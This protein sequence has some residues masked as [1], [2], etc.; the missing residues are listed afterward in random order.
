MSKL[1]AW[2]EERF[3]ISAAT[4]FAA[5]KKVP[6]FYGTVWYYLGGVSLFLFIIQVFTGIL[7]ILY[8][9]PGAATAFESVKFIIT[10]V[11][12]GWLIREIHSWSANLFILFIFAHMFSV[13]FSKAYRKPREMSWYSGMFLMFMALGFGF[14]GYLLPWNELAYFATKVGT[15]IAGAVPGI[16]E[17]VLR[18]LRAGDDVSGATLSRFYGIHVAILPAIFTLILGLHLIMIQVQGMSVPPEQENIPDEQKKYMPFFP[19][20]ALR[21]FLI[22]LVVLNVIALLAVFFPWDLGLKANPLAPAP[23]GIRPEWYFMFM[24][25][26]LKLIPAHVLF[27]EGELLGILTFA[28]G[29]VI[30]FL[31]PFLDRKAHR[32]ERSKGW[33]YFGIALI[34]YMIVLTIWGYSV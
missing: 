18:L 31:V 22:W 25:Q 3:N 12:F 17:F 21:D 16:G 2:I 23:A 8:Y 7:L 5:K 14:S 20:F 24:F 33:K 19:N 32:G 29:G 15:D 1:T 13:F 11:Q 28:F 34:V 26:T 4:K 27:M 10:K 6:L 9:R 30:W